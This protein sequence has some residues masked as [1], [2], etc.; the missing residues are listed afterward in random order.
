MGDALTHTALILVHL[1]LFQSPAN[2]DSAVKEG[3]PHL[4]FLNSSG[5]KDT[6][7]PFVSSLLDSIFSFIHGSEVDFSE[8][9]NLDN[10]YKARKGK[11]RV[12]FTL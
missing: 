7:F 6:C 5:Y 8:P 1:N 3:F 9:N 11:T 12:N 4:G 10:I 2:R